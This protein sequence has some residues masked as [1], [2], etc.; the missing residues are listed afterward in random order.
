MK[1]I[2]ENDWC[3]FYDNE[4]SNP[5]LMQFSHYEDKYYYGKTSAIWFSKIEKFN[6][7]LPNFLKEIKC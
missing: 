3:W 5:I 1:E 7:T 2:K 4:F 6:G